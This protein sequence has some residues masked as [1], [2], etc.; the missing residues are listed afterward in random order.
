LRLRAQRLMSQSSDGVTGVVEVVKQ[1]CGIQGQDATAAT[2]AV[3]VRSAGLVVVDVEQARVQDRTII[4]TWGPR[5]TLHLLAS[6]DIGWLQPLLGPVFVAGDRRRREELGLNE[7]ICE[8]GIHITGSV[9]A[10]HGSLTRSELFEQLANQGIHLGGQA[11]PH[12][13]FRAALEGLICLGPDCGTEPTYVLLNDWIGQEHKGHPLSEDEACA[14]LTR[15]YLSAYGPAKPEDQAAWS[16][17]PLSKIRTAWQ[18]IADQLMEIEFAGSA[19]WMLK[20]CAAWL[21]ELPVHTPIVRLLPRFDIYL[22][23]YQKRDL[24]VQPQYA[25]RINAGGGIIHPTVLVDGRVVGVWKSKREKDHLSVVV[26]PFDELA[27]ELYEGLEAEVTD[28]ARFLGM[29]TTLHVLTSP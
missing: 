18:H 29:P 25:K 23:G 6:D 20:T 26:E 16:G 8:R 7:D 17:L 19:A 15:R 10:K 11:R 3:R 4:R 5:G 2:L 21:D 22:L 9:L 27:P 1:V 13:L 14:E 24:A 12:L 28:L